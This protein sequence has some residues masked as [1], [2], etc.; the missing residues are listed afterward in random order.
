MHKYLWHVILGAQQLGPLYED[1]T[2]MCLPLTD[3][4]LKKWTF[5]SEILS[6]CS[7]NVLEMRAINS[8]Y[9]K[10]G[11][12]MTGHLYNHAGN[13]CDLKNST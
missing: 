7:Q 4:V 9:L 11:D 12:M 3:L 10:T 2:F 1:R 8:P 13:K 5:E 6:D